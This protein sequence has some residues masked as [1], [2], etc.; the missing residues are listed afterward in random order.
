MKTEIITNTN[1]NLS[2]YHVNLLAFTANNVH[3]ILIQSYSRIGEYRREIA[4]E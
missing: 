1:K 3:A 4:Y 2:L